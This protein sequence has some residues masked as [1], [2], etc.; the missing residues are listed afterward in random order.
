MKKNKNEKK[1]Y[2][3]YVVLA[4]VLIIPFMYSF[5]YLKAY[6][7][8]YGKGNIDNIPVAVINADKGDKGESLVN[9]IKDKKK[10]KL[11]VVSTKKATKGLYDGDYYAVITIPE[12]FT[13]NMESASSTNKKHAL[14][15]YS[16]N[17]KSNFLA[18]QIINNVVNVV[19]KNLDNEV[20]STIVKKL[21][22]T[23]ESV[24]EKLDTISDGFTELKQG[25]SK[26]AEGSKTLNDGTTSLAENYAKFNNGV[27][28]V[29]EGT[30]TLSNATEQFNTLNSSLNELVG[31]VSTLKSGSAKFTVGLNSYVDL[32][33][34]MLEQSKTNSAILTTPIVNLKVETCTDG[35][36][37]YNVTSCQTFSY[38]ISSNSNITATTTMIDY[39]QLSGTTLKA[40]NKQ[41][42]DGLTELNTKVSGLSCVGEK[43]TTLQNGIKT[44]NAGVTTLYNSSLQIQSGINT[45]NT[46]ANTLTNG[47]MT[48]DNSVKSAKDELD[49][50]I[51][52]TKKE[53]KKVSGLSNYSKEPVKI[54]TKE[55][56]KVSSYGTAFSPFFI[57]I[58]L[59][60]GSLMMF[61]VLY[62]DKAERFGVLGINSTKRLKRTLS[63]HL[64]AT[65]AAIVLGLTLQL[66]LDF[67]ITNV[68]L[69]YIAIIITSNAFMAI[70]EFLIGNFSDIGKFI[71]LIIL[72]LQLAAAGGTFPI[73]TVTKGFRWMYN[74]LPMTYTV[75]LLREPLVSI[76]SNLLTKN[77]LIVLGVFIVFFA[78][79]IITDIIKEKKEQNR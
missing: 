55:V 34:G 35:S 78:I 40:G 45:L 72:V 44:L 7:N 48:L 5:F 15:T 11:S 60:V 79:N 3:K 59:W 69:Y 30:D 63:Y 20:N 28:S 71:A 17:Q 14:I 41:V 10:L 1:N 58:A 39:I 66:L 32:I 43:I 38:I 65:L 76:E 67:T 68:F 13:S 61:I 51:E 50:N 12:D 26:L 25:T 46:G 16:P 8:P 18:S 21:S 54:K 57:S 9:S 77:L 75:K 47:I 19:E 31:G 56:N 52:T 2:F 37:M 29:K 22:E 49:S 27:K 74:F 23:V 62:Y 24:P 73:E 70:V 64:L 6:W 36:P 53:V 42:N 4:A 33:N